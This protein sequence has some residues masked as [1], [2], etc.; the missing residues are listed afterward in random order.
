MKTVKLSDLIARLA[1]IQAEIG[2]VKCTVLD[3]RENDAPA[4]AFIRSDKKS[5]CIGEPD[6][7]ENKISREQIRAMLDELSVKYRIPVMGEWT[8]EELS[9][10]YLLRSPTVLNPIF[11]PKKK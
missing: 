2:D 11:F 9:D 6:G 10:G 4:T 8:A 1:A 3:R 7:W 5:V